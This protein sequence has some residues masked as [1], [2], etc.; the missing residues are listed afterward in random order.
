M[1][2]PLL[3]GENGWLFLN[4]SRVILKGLDW[5]RLCVW[6]HTPVQR[7]GMAGKKSA[8]LSQHSHI[9]CSARRKLQRKREDS[10]T[11]ST[12]TEC[13]RNWPQ[14]QM[15]WPHKSHPFLSICSLAKP[16]TKDWDNLQEGRTYPQEQEAD[17]SPSPLQA[18]QPKAESGWE[19]G[20]EINWEILQAWV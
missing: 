19:D 20:A 1:G 4:K 5:R 11:S 17:R 9:L 8:L 13:R 6:S 2:C 3:V 16:S 12:S 10:N 14:T 7:A 18:G 15:W